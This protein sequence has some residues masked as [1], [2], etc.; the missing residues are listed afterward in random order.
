MPNS[1]HKNGVKQKGIKMAFR[2]LLPEIHRKIIED[3][4]PYKQIA[5][6]LGVHK[7]TVGRVKRHDQYQG[8]LGKKTVK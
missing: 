5:L 4:R 6:D 2:K 8:I 3:P 7:D 1:R